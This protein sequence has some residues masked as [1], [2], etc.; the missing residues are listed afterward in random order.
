MVRV[1]DRDFNLVLD[2][3]VGATDGTSMI[4]DVIIAKDFVYFTDSF[5]SQFYSV[6]NVFSIDIHVR[7]TYL[8]HVYMSASQ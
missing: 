2:M 3:A 1:Y 7:F 8:K 4:N 6:R 5:R